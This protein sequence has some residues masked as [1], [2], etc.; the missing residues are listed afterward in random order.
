[1]P[2]KELATF[3]EIDAKPEVVW[4]HM[5]AF[6]KYAEWNPF[7]TGL[8]GVAVPGQKVNMTL[9]LRTPDG[10]N[11]ANHVISARVTKVENEHEIRWEHG[12]W[13]SWLLTAEHWC[14]ITQRKGGIKFH[15]C[16]RVE[17]LLTTVMKDDYFAMFRE[18]FTIMNEALKKRVEALEPPKEIR[19]A[20]R[21]TS[22]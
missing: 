16:L 1:M 5:V 2:I 4:P 3:I 14:R 13:F 20:Q 9:K 17:G 7:I 15:Q 11:Q 21:A 19:L 12:A 22:P 18:G 6:H 8:D 10:R